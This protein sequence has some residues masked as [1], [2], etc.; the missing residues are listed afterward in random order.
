MKNPD[1][2][3]RNIGKDVMLKIYTAGDKDSVRRNLPNSDIIQAF[4]A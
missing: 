3:V 4:Q 1:P 2:E